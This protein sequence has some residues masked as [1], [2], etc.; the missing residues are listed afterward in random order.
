MIGREKNGKRKRERKRD[1]RLI[2]KDPKKR[3]ENRAKS[4]EEK[5]CN[6]DEKHRSRQLEDEWVEFWI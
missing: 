4:R 1:Y 6:N 2:A 5:I 3:P